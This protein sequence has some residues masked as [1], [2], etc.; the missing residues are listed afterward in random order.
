MANLIQQRAVQL[1]TIAAAVLIALLLIHPLTAVDGSS[2]LA[3]FDARVGGMSAFLLL[4]VIA[5][6]LLAIA[7][8]ASVAG[9][10]MAGPMAVSIGLLVV[11]WR[12]GSIDGWLYRHALPDA[13]IRLIGELVIWQALLLAVV[14]AIRLLRAPIRNRYP[15]LALNR[16]VGLE[17]AG[18]NLNQTLIAIPFYCVLSALLTVLLVRGTTAPQVCIGLML[19]FGVAGKATQF[20]FPR[21]EA[22]ALM[23][24]PMLVG[25]VGYALVLAQYNSQ[26]QLLAAWYENG[27][28]TFSGLPALAMPMPIHYI[29]AG[30]LGCAI[31]VEYAQGLET[32][33]ADER[34]DE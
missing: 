14:A 6:P 28:A 23:C 26:D 13:Y 7:I 25:I 18:H 21:A 5:L 17:W 4:L 32:E 11:G 33:P 3:L 22:M 1:A 34:P 20:A 8:V 30:T 15:G 27:A 29:A 24:C 12:G 31:G 19:A 10:R 2:G 16:H 9:R